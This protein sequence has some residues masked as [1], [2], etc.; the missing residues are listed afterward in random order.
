MAPILIPDALP[1]LSSLLRHIYSLAIDTTPESELSP[2]D[3]AP[4][5]SRPG[6][7][8]PGTLS[9]AILT[10]FCLLA[11]FLAL[12]VWWFFHIKG[13]FLWRPNDWSDYQSAV[14]R[15]H[16]E[17]S[18]DAITVFTDG[19]ARRGGGGSSAGARTE[20][21][22]A[23]WNDEQKLEAADRMTSI[24]RGGRDLWGEFKSR[25]GIG[26]RGGEAPPMDTWGGRSEAGG[27]SV[28]TRTRI[29]RHVPGRL[30]GVCEVQHFGLEDYERAVKKAE[31]R[32][33]EKM[34]Q[35][36]R[37]RRESLMAEQQGIPLQPQKPRRKK[38]PVRRDWDNRSLETTTTLAAPALTATPVS[39]RRR[40]YEYESYSKETPAR[41]KGWKPEDS[42]LPDVSYGYDPKAYFS[43]KHLSHHISTRTNRS[44]V[45]GDDPGDV[46]PPIRMKPKRKSMP[47]PTMQ[48]EPVSLRKE[49]TRK[50]K[51]KSSHGGAISRGKSHRHH[52]KSKEVS[53]KAYKSASTKEVGAKGYVAASTKEITQGAG[54]SKHHSSRR[55]VSEKTES[56]KFTSSEEYSSSEDY[57]ESDSDEYTTESDSADEKGN[58]KKPDLGTK[59]YHHPLPPK[60][61]VWNEPI[62]RGSG[63][64]GS[65]SVA[66]SAIISRNNRAEN[67]APPQASA[68]APA[69]PGYRHTRAN[70]I[71]MERV[72]QFQSRANAAAAP[73]P[74]IRALPAP[75]TSYSNTPRHTGSACPAPPGNVKALGYRRNGN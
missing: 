73:I 9:A 16:D 21:L 67:T 75:G 52:S 47:P 24:S 38:K 17:I 59:V 33:K 20:V 35:K 50:D 68:A 53:G 48:A 69:P 49:S 39:G 5:G 28:S 11:T 44:Y 25:L 60:R 40:D 71:V 29:G 23:V 54:Y 45:P 66:G 10:V 22:S 3:L 7:V 15:R 65:S 56:T 6:A 74:T 41:P 27:T 4:R 70:S 72:Q 58:P 63:N 13:G 26:L 18:D 34:R 2:R 32:N 55:H 30:P 1:T 57:T 36:E 64:A 61:E 12:L 37:E 31:A 62:A 14:L 8:S 43:P 42:V 51:H 46:P 19:S